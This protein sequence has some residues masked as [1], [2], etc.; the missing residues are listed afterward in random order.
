MR[1]L[2]GLCLLILP[3]CRGSAQP[4]TLKG[5]VTDSAG[6]PLA[7][8]EVRLMAEKTEIGLTRTGEDGR[9]AVGGVIRGRS[10][11]QVQHPGFKPADVELFFPRD[12]LR[13]LSIELE[14]VSRNVGELQGRDSSGA[15][16]L[17][18]FYERR[19]S[20]GHGQYFTREEIVARLP[21]YPSE[22]LRGIPGVAISSRPGGFQ[23]RFRGCRYAPVVWIDGTRA[24]NSELDDVAR[25]DEIAAM[26]VYAT[27]AGTPAQYLDR[28]NVGCGTILVWSLQ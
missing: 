21:Q 14:P 27:P 4:T 24:L 9:F 15:A 10:G 18:K 16:R 19:R 3:F 23:I 25:V 17:Q 26:E 6:R 7:G 13:L 2:T 28:S 8:A 22:M 11:L 1:I 20:N 5:T 12:S